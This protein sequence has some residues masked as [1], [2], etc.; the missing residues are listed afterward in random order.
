MENT[1]A[2]AADW[3]RIINTGSILIEPKAIWEE[4]TQ[5]GTNKFEHS[6]FGGII[7]PY[8]I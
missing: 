8:D 2:V 4:E 6:D 3:P 5:T 1:A 7:E